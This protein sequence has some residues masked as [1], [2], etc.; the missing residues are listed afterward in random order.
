MLQEKASAVADEG[1]TV[2]QF[3][4]LAT[5]SSHLGLPVAPSIHHNNEVDQVKTMPDGLTLFR[6]PWYWKKWHYFV[7]S[8]QNYKSEHTIIFHKFSNRVRKQI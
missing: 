8:E 2:A 1:V 5:D 7:E 3:G 6:L 4:E